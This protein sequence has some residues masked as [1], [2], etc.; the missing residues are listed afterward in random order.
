M[1]LNQASG[2]WDVKN[3]K[4]KNFRDRVWFIKYWADYIRNNEDK[5]WSLGQAMLIDSQIQS[6]R[7]FYESLKKTKD[8]RKKLSG[9]IKR[10]SMKY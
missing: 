9:F 10:L 1:K 8:G 6:S 4:M 3:E 2:M 5:K 7:S